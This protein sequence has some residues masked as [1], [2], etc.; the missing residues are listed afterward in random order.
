VYEINVVL[1][2]DDNKR[3]NITAGR[4][5]THIHSYAAQFAEFLGVGLADHS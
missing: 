5:Y 2:E 3:I 1:K 4:D